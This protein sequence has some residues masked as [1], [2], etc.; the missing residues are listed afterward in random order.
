MNFRRLSYSRW[1]LLGAVVALTAWGS[2]SYAVEPDNF[3]PNDS[4]H[5][6]DGTRRTYCT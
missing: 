6:R 3:R 1:H 5:G 2:P 4:K